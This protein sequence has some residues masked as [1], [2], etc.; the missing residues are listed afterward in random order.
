M[1]N[2]TILITGG[3]GFIGSNFIPFFLEKHDTVSVVNLDKLTYAGNLGHLEEVKNNERYKFVQGDICDADLVRAIFKNEQISDVIHFA[4]ESHVDNSIEGPETFIKTNINGTFTLLEGARE[5]WLDNSNSAKKGFE[6][7]RF[8]HISTDEVF[9]SLGESGFF[10][11][12]TAYAPNSPYSAS[13][14]S[15]DFLVRSYFHTYGLNVITTNCSNNYGPK[16]HDEKL[17]PTIIRKALK[18]EE[19]PIYGDGKNVR[20]WLYVQDHCLGIDLAFSKGK[21]GE[22]YVIGGNNE[23]SNIFIAQKICTILDEVYPK[24]TGNYSEQIT[25]VRDRLGHDFRYAIDATKIK[26]KLGWQSK[27]NFDSGLR[28]TVSWYMNKYQQG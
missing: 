6:A 11:E 2:R 13:K 19:I 8:H 5:H 17:I 23:H 15:S 14:A 24:K 28:E 21:I 18:G 4:A 20:D 3:A 16:Q 9:G 1:S 7:S 12:N 22:T 25:F 26:T 10:D 27:W